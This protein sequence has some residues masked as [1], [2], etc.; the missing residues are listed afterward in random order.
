MIV[1][2]LHAISSRG[3]ANYLEDARITG[4]V[5]RDKEGRET[6]IAFYEDDYSQLLERHFPGLQSPEVGGSVATPAPPGHG[7]GTELKKLLAGWP[8]YI[9]SSPDCSCNRVAA[10]MDSWG[11]DVCEEPEKQDYIL[12]A[13]RENAEKRGLPFIDA[14]GRFLIRRAIKNARKEQRLTS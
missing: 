12:A 10:E 9:T 11:A 14:A 8:F 13:M 3:L 4:T 6:H 5:I 1:V 2:P 7:P